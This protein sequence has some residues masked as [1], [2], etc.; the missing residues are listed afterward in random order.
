MNTRDEI[1]RANRQMWEAEV[2]KG[3][4]FTTPWLD[5][6]ISLLR[7]YARGEIDSLPEPLTSLSPSWV[8]ADV[9][10][11]D[12]LCLASG[13]GQQSA[14]F[15]LLR[16]KVTV[17]D[18]AAGQ[19]AGDRQAA[20]RYGY[21]VDVLQADMRNLSCI[22]DESFDLVYQADSFAYI[23]DVRQVYCEVGRVLKTGGLYR[24][25]HSQPA[26]H[27]VCWDGARYS[28]TTPYT[29]NVDRRE[30]GGIEFR[31]YL[32][33]IFGGLGDAALELEEVVDVGR[34]MKPDPTAAPGSWAHQERYVGGGFVIVARKRAAPISRVAP[35]SQDNKD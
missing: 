18:L 2:T 6:D 16:A 17:A 35:P 14:V 19:L 9:E 21:R 31:H 23:P 5:L 20:S 28:V 15:G 29:E 3:C 10:D 22:R 13:G 30:D 34:H 4:G 7:R 25:K 11:K 12:V 1:A 33:D 32:D 24:A 27:F 8:L 26:V